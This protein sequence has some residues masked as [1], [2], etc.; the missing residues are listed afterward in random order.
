MAPRL[1]ATIAL[2]CALGCH[3]ISGLT[4]FVAAGGSSSLGG[5]GGRANPGGAGGQPNAGSGGGAAGASAST[6]GSG[7]TP[8]NL[9]G[10]APDLLALYYFDEAENGAVTSTTVAD[11]GP[12][13]IDLSADGETNL[14]F[15]STPKGR[16]L[17]WLNFNQGGT[18]MGTGM[19]DPLDA[20]STATLELVIALRGEANCS[21]IVHLRPVNN[22]FVLCAK[23]TG[24]LVLRMGNNTE[25]RNWAFDFSVRSVVHLTLDLTNADEQQRALLY[26]NGAPVPNT[27][28]ATIDDGTTFIVP[29]DTDVFFGTNGNGSRSPIGAIYYAA[30]YAE[31]MSPTDIAE[32]AAKL[33]V[34]D[35]R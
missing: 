5:A 20:T 31:V 21:R 29:E 14:E 23:D 28:S 22:E 27:A 15:T 7:G 4:D 10:A 17:R 30:L 11:H 9:G 12:R 24:T 33:N 34:K 8:V 2:C 13:G 35:D 1:V 32:R 26:A 16:G 25:R 3:E 6:G 19:A 18:V